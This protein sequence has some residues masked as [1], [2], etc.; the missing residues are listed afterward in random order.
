MRCAVRACI[1][2]SSKYVL[3]AYELI[4]LQRYTATVHANRN[5]TNQTMSCYYTDMIHKCMHRLSG[6]YQVLTPFL[7]CA[8]CIILH[9]II[10]KATN[11]EVSA[12]MVLHTTL[13]LCDHF[14]RTLAH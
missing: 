7:G 10:T 2:V 5:S 6:H 3:D 4:A 14:E 13:N 9:A 1:S 11:V 8:G 12:Q